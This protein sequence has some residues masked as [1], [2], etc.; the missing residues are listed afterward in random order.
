MVAGEGEGEG[1]G[2]KQAG[3]ALGVGRWK[4]VGVTYHGESLDAE[5]ERVGCHVSRVR[6]GVFLPELGKEVLR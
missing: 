1:S 6:E 4:L 2:G 3:D 5:H